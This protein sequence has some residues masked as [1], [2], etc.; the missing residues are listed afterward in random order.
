VKTSVVKAVWVVT[1]LT[2]FTRV[3]VTVA[4]V[5]VC[6][7]NVVEGVTK[8][9]Q[10]FEM[11]ERANARR[12]ELAE[13]IIDVQTGISSLGSKSRSLRRARTV[14]AIVVN[15]FIVEVECTVLN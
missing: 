9:E 2:V 11:I 5:T 6:P 3:V 4:L 7:I 12:T 13:F 15:V 1:W 14:G 8:Q 10:A